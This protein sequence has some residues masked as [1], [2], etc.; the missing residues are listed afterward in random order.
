[1]DQVLDQFRRMCVSA[2]TESPMMRLLKLA[3]QRLG[4]KCDYIAG[5][6]NDDTRFVITMCKCD[7]RNSY[8]ELLFALHVS[9]DDKLIDVFRRTKELNN[10]EKAA[11][12]D[13]FSIISKVP[14]HSFTIV[15]RICHAHIHR[16]FLIG[17][18]NINYKGYFELSLRVN[19]FLEFANM[20]TDLSDE[21]P[22]IVMAYIIPAI[23]LHR[24]NT[25]EVVKNLESC[26]RNDA[27]AGTGGSSLT[28]WPHMNAAN[29]GWR[30]CNTS[31]INRMAIYAAGT[32][33]NDCRASLFD[34]IECIV[35]EAT[36]FYMRWIRERGNFRIC[37]M[38]TNYFQELEKKDVPPGWW[39]TKLLDI[40]MNA[41]IPG[42]NAWYFNGTFNA[43]SYTWDTGKNM[44]DNTRPIFSP[45]VIKTCRKKAYEKTLDIVGR[46]DISKFLWIDALCID[47][48]NEQKVINEV[49]RSHEYY[50]HCNKCIVMPAGMSRI[51]EVAEL[52]SQILPKWFS[53]A[54]TLQE[55][56]SAEIIVG[57]F[58]DATGLVY[59]DRHEIA[60]HL[61]YNVRQS[62]VAITS[63]RMLLK[64]ESL[65]TISPATIIEWALAKNACKVQDIIYGIQ[66][67]L[68]VS[69][70]VDYSICIQCVIARLV[71]A[72][73]GH[74][75][76]SLVT[77]AGDGWM[78]KIVKD[79]D[80][81]TGIVTTSY[82]DSSILSNGN[83]LIK[84]TTL[85]EVTCASY[86]CK[87]FKCGDGYKKYSTLPDKRSFIANVAAANSEQRIDRTS[88]ADN[89]IV[90][91][92]VA[93]TYSSSDLVKIVHDKGVMVARIIMLNGDFSHLIFIGYAEDSPYLEQVYICAIKKERV[94]HKIGVI[95]Q[96]VGIK[97]NERIKKDDIVIASGRSCSCVPQ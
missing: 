35:E 78:P 40:K 95:V 13:V 61:D 68:A 92:W 74:H 28:M 4:T 60:R 47:Q 67:M 2:Q 23:L 56:A 24:R 49:T 90:R 66:S 20:F 72:L 89:A 81:L 73:Q 12:L 1:M 45:R 8:E 22:V 71:G 77:L 58:Q 5:W 88:A 11:S 30:T 80:E 82:L 38:L 52:D 62:G 15:A 31:A 70:P 36:D 10:V 46:L 93:V 7:T 32:L 27:A 84:E 43:L 44:F 51:P 18:C 42:E 86:Y 57:V 79:D 75:R 83:L 59:L 94:F 41:L 19:N 64:R 3:R 87:V 9:V 53:R 50:K 26:M 97:Y 76:S 65:N 33:M 29:L 48:N 96:P 25:A 21:N 6:A 16:L 69:V 39:P 55:A 63:A 91:A 85:I 34:E 17:E 54:W 37:E 14:L